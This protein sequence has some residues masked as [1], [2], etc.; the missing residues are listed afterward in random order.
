M[1]AAAWVTLIVFALFVPVHLVMIGVKM[2]EEDPDAAGLHFFGAIFYSW[3]V[4][5]IYTLIYLA[6]ET[7]AIT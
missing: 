4:Y 5:L 3:I 7:P 1:L 6:Y 2:T